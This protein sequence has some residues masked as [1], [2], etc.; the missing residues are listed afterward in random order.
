[1][2]VYTY[3][4]YSNAD[5]SGNGSELFPYN[6]FEDAMANVADGGTISIIDKGFING[7]DNNETFVFDK[8]RC[9]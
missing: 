2:N 9:V 4:Q 5:T 1:M 6:R 7:K 3:K 8:A